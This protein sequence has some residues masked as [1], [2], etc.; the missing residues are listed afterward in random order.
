MIDFM[1]NIH[2]E[3]RIAEAQSDASRAKDE[4]TTYKK[5]IRDLEFSLNRMALVSQ[6]MWELLSS[7]LGIAESELLAR[8]SEIDLRDGVAVGHGDAHAHADGDAGCDRVGVGD[9]DGHADG[10]G[11]ALI[12]PDADDDTAL[13]SHAAQRL[14]SAA[15]RRQGKAATAQERIGQ[16]S[17]QVA[18][19]EGRRQP[20]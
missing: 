17:A 1:W 18:L 19:V 5:Q 7:R 14:Q 15:G 10:H 6:A 11:N 16:R 4:V 12:E 3:G 9:R 2:Q 20:D 8:M 13:C